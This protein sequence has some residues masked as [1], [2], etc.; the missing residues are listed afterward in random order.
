MYDAETA[1][2]RSNGDRRVSR[3]TYNIRSSHAV[4]RWSH[5]ARPS[6][7]QKVAAPS[8]ASRIDDKKVP[9]NQGLVPQYRSERDE[10]G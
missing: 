9:L 3:H 4:R 1:K 8:R 6:W 5:R 2:I 7:R 10:I